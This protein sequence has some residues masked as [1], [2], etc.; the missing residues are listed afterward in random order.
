MIPIHTKICAF[1][2]YSVNDSKDKDNNKIY[3]LKA[4][5]E[6]GIKSHVKKLNVE[7]DL[8]SYK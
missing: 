8:Y 1:Y 6:S 3:G 5:Y 4:I 7:R 2:A